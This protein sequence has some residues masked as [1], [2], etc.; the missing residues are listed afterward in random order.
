MKVIPLCDGTYA[1]NCYLV[2]D[3]AAT[4]AI[5]IDPSLSPSVAERTIGALPPIDA[6][7]LTHGHFDHML[8]LDEWRL[9]TSAPL[10]M[11]SYDAPALSDP[12]VSCYRGFLHKETVHAPADGFLSGGDSVAVGQEVLTVIETPGHT[13]GSLCL[14]SGSLLFTGD[15]LFANGGYGRYDLPGGDVALLASS[16]KAL[17]SLAGQRRILSGHGEETTLSDAKQYF[18]FLRG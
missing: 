12:A 1:S 13:P 17:L 2:S 9:R 14:D 6:I 4:G 8:A 15:T 16:L 7:V 5:L 3:D 11:S 18:N 10:L